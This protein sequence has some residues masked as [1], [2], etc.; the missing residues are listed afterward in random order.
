[1]YTHVTYNICNTFIVKYFNKII[2]DNLF[3]FCIMEPMRQRTQKKKLR[4]T[5]ILILLYRNHDLLFSHLDIVHSCLD[6][7]YD[8]YKAI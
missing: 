7:L 6:I 3:S 2:F 5:I 4:H 1:M 8:K